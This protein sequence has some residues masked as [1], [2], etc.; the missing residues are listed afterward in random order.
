MKL[1]RLTNKTAQASKRIHKIIAQPIDEKKHSLPVPD[2]QE[3][4]A[5]QAERDEVN[6]MVKDPRL[7]PD[8]KDK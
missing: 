1:H 7:T 3:R 5:T 8:D 6:G 2:G 4:L